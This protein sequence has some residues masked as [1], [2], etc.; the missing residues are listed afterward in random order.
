MKCK[1]ILAY[2]AAL[3]FPTLASEFTVEDLNRSEDKQNTWV[4]LPYAFSTDSMGLT[5]GAVLLLD[6]FIQPQMTMVF[7][8]FAGEDLDTQYG[9]NDTPDQAR[10]KGGIYSISGYRP[11]FSDRLFISSLGSYAYYPNQRLYLD[12]S[13]S[14][15]QNLSTTDPNN[16]SPLQT[17]GYNNWF[18]VNFSY[19]LPWG[20]SKHNVLPDIQLRRGLP[21][22][23]DHVGGGQVFTSGQTLLGTELFYTR[24]TADR[25]TEAPSLNTN[26][27]RLFLE[28]DNTDYPSNPS[29]GY[30]FK[31]TSSI[32][33]GLANSTQSWNSLEF[34][35]K[36]Y[37]E[38]PTLP[39]MRQSVLAFNAW[40]A[41]S[42][43]WDNNKKL[44]PGG[45]LQKNQTPMWEGAHL[46]GWNRMRA[47]DSNRFNDKAAV[48]G[49]AEYRF[50]PQLNP[51]ADQKWNPFPIDWFQLVLFA[52]VGRVAEQYNTELF[53]D[54]KYDVGFSVRALAAKTPVRFDMAW[55]EEGSSMWVMLNQPF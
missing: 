42:P 43:S 32:D 53:K 38:L 20:E 40:T 15:E 24:W 51:M 54:M 45:I 22:N 16:I 46:G 30:A 17:Q 19:I 7:T 3:S 37:I 12:G 34:D 23:R 47:Y 44:N 6:G 28:H 13:N 21:V 2:C 50:I 26:G 8:V 52:E 9:P 55:G 33:F 48:Y 1:F 31:A 41:Y 35:Y 39:W 11:S 25:F 18:N 36:H 14:S 5:A 4:V 27:I 49:A 10:A 29:R